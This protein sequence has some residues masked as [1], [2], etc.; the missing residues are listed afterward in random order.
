MPLRTSETGDASQPL[1]A[2]VLRGAWFGAKFTFW[3][4]VALVTGPILGMLAVRLIGRPGFVA[5]IFSLDVL[6]RYLVPAVVVP[7]AGASLG[8]VVAGVLFPLAATLNGRPSRS[9]WAVEEEQS[10]SPFDDPPP[11]PRSREEL[12]RRIVGGS[13]Q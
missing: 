13:T 10:A 11:A 2:T 12:L 7:L 6:V 1:A 9:E 4:L 5:Y 3:L 8:A